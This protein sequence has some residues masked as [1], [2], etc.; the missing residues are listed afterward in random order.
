VFLD[1]LF[2]KP[3]DK[4]TQKKRLVRNSI[5]SAPTIHH[6]HFVRTVEMERERSLMLTHTHS[7]P[8]RSIPAQVVQV[9]LQRSTLTSE[10]RV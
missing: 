3:V 10:P 8:S 9:L 5:P 4:D 2:T 1:I 7:E 6:P